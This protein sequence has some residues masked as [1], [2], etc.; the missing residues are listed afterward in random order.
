MMTCWCEEP[1][2][3]QAE[4]SKLLCNN[5]MPM[6]SGGGDLIFHFYLDRIF[7]NLH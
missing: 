2:E 4:D 5:P 3:H 1:G 6:I 7:I